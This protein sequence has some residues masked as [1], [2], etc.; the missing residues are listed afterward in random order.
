MA[1]RTHGGCL[2]TQQQRLCLLSLCASTQKK[3]VR[4]VAVFLHRVS[5]WVALKVTQDSRAELLRELTL[6]ANSDQVP[7]ALC[8]AVTTLHTCASAIYDHGSTGT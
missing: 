2:A 1:K 7:G 5:N 6:T 3:Q 4:S 8:T